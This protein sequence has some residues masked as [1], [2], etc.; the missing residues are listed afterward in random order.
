M[1]TVLGDNNNII[2]QNIMSDAITYVYS[3]II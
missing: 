2:T 1:K 3:Q